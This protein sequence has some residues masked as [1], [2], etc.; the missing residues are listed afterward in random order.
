[1]SPD[2]AKL[3]L[4]MPSAYDV[5]VKA[6]LGG[7]RCTLIDLEHRRPMAPVVEPGEASTVRMQQFS[8]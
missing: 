3:A 5:G 1:M 7:Y 4:Y 6:D 8:I 2:G